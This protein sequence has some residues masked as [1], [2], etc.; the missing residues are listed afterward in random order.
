[1]SSRTFRPMRRR[2]GGRPR[3]RGSGRRWGFAA[4]GLL[5]LAGAWMAVEW[6]LRPALAAAAQAVAVRA[7]TEALNAAVTE[8]MVAGNGVSRV[9]VVDE[10]DDHGVRV[11]HFDF[12]EVAR[13]QTE[14]TE[15]AEGHLRALSSETL[16]LPV[17]QAVGGL[18]LTNVGLTLPVRVYMMGTA[19]TSVSAEV[20][21]VGVNQTVH[22]LYLDLAADV[23]AVAPL[24]TA[25][26]HVKTRVLL[27]YI[28]L[29]GDVPGSYWG[30]SGG[31]GAVQPA[32]AR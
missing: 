26:A 6:K 25:P 27:A 18:V 21:S 29:N 10:R 8:E 12:T 22:T 13:V 4:G 14:A 7:A 3:G 24:V 17:A 16:R 5:A 19:H 1:M 9:L 31:G 32:P 23:Q 20:R 30:A 11:A 15:R 2:L 28:V